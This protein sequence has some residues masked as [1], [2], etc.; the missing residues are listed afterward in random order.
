MATLPTSNRQWRLASYPEGL[1]TEADWTLSEG[2][3]PT[4]GPNQILLRAI[5]LDVAPYMRGRISPQ[6]NY[7]AGVK[8]G[9]V[10]LG[11]GIGE[12]V[13]SNT[14]HYKP[15]DVVVT[16][17]SFGWQEY[18]ALQPSAVRKVDPSLAPLPYWM[19]A[20]GLNGTTAYFALLDAARIK[21]GDTVVISAA[22]GSV[23][24]IAGQIVKLAGGRAVGVTSSADKAAWCRELGY[25]EIVDYRAEADDLPGAIRKACPHGVD[26][27]IDNTAGVISEAVMQNLAAHAR[28]VLVGSI[29]LSGKFGQPDIGLR[30]HRQTMI[31]RATIQGFLVS[32]Y[33][34]RYDEARERLVSW[35]RAGVLKSKFDIAKG[36]ENLPNAF[37]RLMK[38]ENT[39]KQ[40]VQVGEEPQRS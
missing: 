28:I 23:G 30:F 18:A 7:A 27:Y 3:V 38:S 34:Q 40:M 22:A 17:F 9:D 33:T 12:V 36:F 15:G 29:S 20:F 31:A 25:D 11:G 2:T 10:M 37:L 24:Q 4:P 8:P 19:E 14:K 5:Y 35:Y 39:G 1:P 16:D 26:V 21:P 32:D 6:K 13:Q